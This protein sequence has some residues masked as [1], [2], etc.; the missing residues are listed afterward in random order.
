MVY[1]L[2]PVVFHKFVP[3]G[4]DFPGRK[5]TIVFQGR[6]G[7][8]LQPR[9]FD[10]GENRNAEDRFEAADIDCS[11]LLIELYKSKIEDPS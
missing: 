2:D 5:A 4:S 1:E 7:N 6:R 10:F 8:L 3:E 11:K 9:K